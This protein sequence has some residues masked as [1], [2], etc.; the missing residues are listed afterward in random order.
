MMQTIDQHKLTGERALFKSKDLLIIN[1][2]FADGESPLKESNDITIR[3]SIFK[4][5]YP[6]WYCDNI[7]VTD[8][9]LLETARSGIWYTH[10]ISISASVVEAPK[11][12]RRSSGIRLTN[13]SLPNAQETLWNCK[14]IHMNH[15]TAK[16]DYFGMNSENIIIDNFTLTGNYAFDGAKNIEIRN[17]KNFEGCIL[18]LRECHCL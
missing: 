1:S 17:A 10:Q 4:W 3:N 6:L 2:I 7:Q 8:S 18:E 15:V 16:G 12:F 14:D 5:K 11:T 13:V 9:T